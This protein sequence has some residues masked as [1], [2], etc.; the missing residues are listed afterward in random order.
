MSKVKATV[1][2]DFRVFAMSPEGGKERPV[3]FKAGQEI[4]CTPEQLDAGVA[5]GHLE[6]TAA[7]ASRLATK[8]MAGTDHRNSVEQED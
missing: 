8:P 4:D 7:G 6:A 5:A 2:R 3:R 1:L